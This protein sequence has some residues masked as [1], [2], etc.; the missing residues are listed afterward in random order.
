MGDATQRHAQRHARSGGVHAR[1]D[2]CEIRL[3]QQPFTAAVAQRKAGIAEGAGD[4]DIVAGARGVAAQRL[5]AGHIAEHGDGQRE[6]PLGRIAADQFAAVG[7]GQHQHAGGQF[8][9]PGGVRLGQGQRERE[10]A[11]FGAH[12]GEIG[13]IDRQC[14]M[15]ERTRRHIGE[16]M[17]TADQ[18]VGADGQLMARTAVDQRAIVAHAQRGL[19]HWPG[20]EL[21][22]QVEFGKRGA[23]GVR[24]GGWAFGEKAEEITGGQALRHAA[25]C[26]ETQS[27]PAQNA[28]CEIIFH[29]IKCA[30]QKA[31]TA[32]TWSRPARFSANFSAAP[33]IGRCADDQSSAVP[34]PRRSETTAA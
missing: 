18:H 29:N 12:R 32:G 2:D 8:G 27:C 31:E 13:E 34:V 16:E 17:A 9:Q 1:P 33:P 6:R 21:A 14:L 7:I 23:G 4:P 19:V 30:V 10:G 15:A 25:Y 3:G 24:H 28:Y 11:W 22:N 26:T 5:T 20:E